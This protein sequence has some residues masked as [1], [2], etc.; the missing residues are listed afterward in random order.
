MEIS[1]SVDI[2]TPKK[3]ENP[4]KNTQN[5]GIGVLRT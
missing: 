1:D 2:Y 3:C 4:E 5:G